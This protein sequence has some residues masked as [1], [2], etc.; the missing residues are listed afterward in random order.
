M[1]TFKKGNFKLKIDEYIVK[2]CFFFTEEGELTGSTSEARAVFVP[3]VC[4]K[5]KIP[6]LQGYKNKKSQ[7]SYDCVDG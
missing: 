4:C 2:M 1:V 5:V 6:Q 3:S 7:L